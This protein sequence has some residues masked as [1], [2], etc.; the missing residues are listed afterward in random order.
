ML[1]ATKK[2]IIII[3]VLL[4]LFM[5]VVYAAEAGQLGILGIAYVTDFDLGS[6]RLPIF[7]IPW[8]NGSYFNSANLPTQLSFGEEAWI[9]DTFYLSIVKPPSVANNGQ[10]QFTME[11]RVV[12]P[13]NYT[14]TEG[15]TSAAIQSGVYSTVASSLSALTVNPGG[16][17][18]ITFSFKTK[19]DIN[20]YD[21]TRIDVSYMMAGL[22]RYFHIEI[23]MRPPV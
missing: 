20:S 11:F 3:N 16:S 13:T 2:I 23:L 5:G 12:N 8:P 18:V 14:W 9:E 1:I 4:L 21:L 22:R 10:N 19:I 15:L 17:V 6:D 7:P